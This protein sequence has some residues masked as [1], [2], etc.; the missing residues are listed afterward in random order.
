MG[1]VHEACVNDT[2]YLLR[3]FGQNEPTSVVTFRI[4]V[5]VEF[6]RIVIK[7]TRAITHLIWFKLRL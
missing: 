3:R 1:I 2:K 5:L 6:Q 7:I 4:F